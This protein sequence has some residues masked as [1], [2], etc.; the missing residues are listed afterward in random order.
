MDALILQLPVYITALGFGGLIG[1]MVK[2][3]LDNNSELKIRLK[4]IN[5]EKYRTI[6]IYMSLALSPQKKSQFKLND[7]V[8]LDLRG[9]GEIRDYV[10]SK[11][12]EYYYQSLLYASDSVLKSFKSFMVD[13]SRENY[14]VVAREMRMDLWN[15]K[16]KLTISEI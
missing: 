6:L 12:Y 5:E 14:I 7:S 4:T 15:K 11:L 16:T 3:F 13:P 2:S 9:E 8:L 1:I 10:I